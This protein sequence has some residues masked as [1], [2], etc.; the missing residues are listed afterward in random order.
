MAESH[1]HETAT[2]RGSLTPE[3]F[4]RLRR[5]FEE[6]LE[7]R[8]S[9]RQAF[10]ENACAGDRELLGEIQGMLIAE[11]KNED[12]RGGTPS[13]SAPDEGR[14]PAGTVLAGR[15]RI[16][17]LLGKGGMGEVY[18]AFD[19]ILNQT[20]AL[21]FLTHAHLGEAAL[22]RFR[23][24][25]RIARQVSH[26][27]VC[28]V[29]DVGMVEGLHFLSMEYID[30]ED[31]ASLLRRIGRLPQD[32]AIEFT[33]KIC[34]GL[35]AAHERGVLH[36]DLKPTNIMIDGRGQPR[37]AD[38]G[39]AA[40][41]QEIP[42]S[43]LRS[44]TPAYMSPEQKA[45]KEVTTRSD[46]YSLGLV[47]H[48]MFTGKA[49]ANDRKAAQSTPSELV[50]ELDP[51]IERLILRCL[52]EDPRRRPSSVLSVAM[53]LPGAD[54]IAAA[55]A[56]GETPSPEM[57]AASQ[58]KEGF[59]SRTAWLCFVALLA[60]LVAVSAIHGKL[61][62]Q[63][64]APLDIPPDALAFRAQTILRQL[65]YQEKPADTAYGIDCCD[66]DF[67]LSLKNSDPARRDAVLATH[68][69]A[70][71][72]FWYRQH[73]LRFH[74][75]SFL[76]NSPVPPNVGLEGAVTYGSPPNTEPGMIR[77]KLSP[78]GDLA[79][80]EVQPPSAEATDGTI[81]SLD[82]KALLAVAGLD[83]ARFM[84]IQPERVPPMAVDTRA[85]WTGTY[86]NGRSERIRVEAATWQGR[87]VFF[88]IRG[89]WQ[90]G[91][92]PAP[93]PRFY[94][95]RILFGAVIVLVS[96]GGILAYRNLRQGRGDRRGALWIALLSF[97][98]IFA[99]WIPL[100]HHVPDPWE[101]TLFTKALCWAV[102]NGVGT[103]I[104]YLAIEPYARR[105][106]PDAF[107]SLTRLQSG[108]FRDPLVA[109]H[110]LGG[111][112]ASLAYA[113]SVL[114][115]VWLSSGGNALFLPRIDALN[116]PAYASGVL[117]ND[118]ARTLGAPLPA[119]VLLV[120][121]RQLSRRT[122]L[123]YVLSAIVLTGGIFRLGFADSWIYPPPA[124]FAISLAG[125]GLLFASVHRWGVLAFIAWDFI[126]LLLSLPL[127]ASAWYTG[128]T[129]LLLA[130]PAAVAAWALWVIL[131]AQRRITSE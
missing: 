12:L 70:I 71:I 5:I 69:P 75:D 104:L 16:L 62:L 107:I 39:L 52:E 129:L 96:A 22:I 51:T 53:A 130:L 28:R 114:A 108:R 92:E 1:E 83:P 118:V 13:S 64:R 37:I 49:R 128:Q 15:Y 35:G 103:A 59:S 115:I 27:N 131:A 102:F 106:W 54:P 85:A 84:P 56:A 43:D 60:L 6:A 36:R 10:L 47:L 98:A 99:S 21:K 26:P 63:A 19:L 33:R 76:V 45:G 80:L 110:I 86:A 11:E 44:G 41:A 29:Y 68:R 46:V 50:K 61:D 111:F 91:T 113:A 2:V 90:K 119:L 57:V 77:M 58:E 97:G 30:G 34:A 125:W 120:L 48:E 73:Y 88:D 72:R 65:G 105:F 4:A 93:T 67:L 100:A 87:I 122:W 74:A 31:L 78:K 25:V 38:F 81:P 89:D 82:W 18:K 24:E 112:S 66:T 101:M 95:I 23:N 117:L 124:G 9:E 42:L 94:A 20:V 40:L 109:S 3:H 126:G 121:M 123:A 8:P 17:G 7:R 127:E 32:K 116:G 14:F 55:L 79:A